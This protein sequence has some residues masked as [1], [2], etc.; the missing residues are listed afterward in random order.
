MDDDGLYAILG[1]W[2]DLAESTSLND[3][4]WDTFA[5]AYDLRKT[6]QKG[7]ECHLR[8]TASS[9]AVRLFDALYAL[10]E[11]CERWRLKWA[12]W[13]DGRHC[14]LAI[15]KDITI[16]AS[17]TSEPWLQLAAK[18]EFGVE[19]WYTLAKHHNLEIGEIG[20]ETSRNLRLQNHTTAENLFT[21]LLILRD[22]GRLVPI[23]WD[24]LTQRHVRTVTVVESGSGTF[25]S[26]QLPPPHEQHPTER[27][28]ST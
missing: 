20:P 18:T 19:F 8:L 25:D 15:A 7:Q 9:T 16:P 28:K 24:L 11:I 6:Q 3:S 26:S 13:H 5:T 23:D 22:I 2:Y 12:P 4:F 1:L 27:S 14:A 17:T 21:C 10:Y